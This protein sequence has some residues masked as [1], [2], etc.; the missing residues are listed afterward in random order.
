MRFGEHVDQRGQGFNRFAFVDAR[1]QP[2]G[3]FV[4]DDA[5]RLGLPDD[6]LGD[7]VDEE[8]FP[9]R[10]VVHLCADNGEQLIGG[11]ARHFAA[12]EHF[13]LQPRD[14]LRRHPAAEDHRADDRSA[15]V[16]CE[17]HHT[18]LH[19]VRSD[20]GDRRRLGCGGTLRLN[21]F[22]Q[23]NPAGA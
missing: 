19:S 17:S 21:N 4:V 8:L 14:I 1:Q 10:R 11:F 22:R 5:G 16:D 12:G 9:L 23:V 15:P 2:N 13:P 6:V 3:S 7:H 20:S 18:H